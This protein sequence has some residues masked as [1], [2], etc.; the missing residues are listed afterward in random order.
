M[1]TKSIHNKLREVGVVV[2]QYHYVHLRGWWN[3]A[4]AHVKSTS[5][6][7]WYICIDIPIII[8]IVAA[9]L[10]ETFQ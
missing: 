8:Y 2:R 5:T 4:S 7:Y 9:Q 10:C 3:I 6:S 1:R